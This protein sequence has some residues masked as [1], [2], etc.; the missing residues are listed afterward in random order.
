MIHAD[1]LRRSPVDIFLSQPRAAI[2]GSLL[3]LIAATE[4][5]IAV[6]R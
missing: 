1:H 4:L 5:L 2:G 3:C 6:L